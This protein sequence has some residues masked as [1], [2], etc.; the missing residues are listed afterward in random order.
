MNRCLSTDRSIDRLNLA[1]PPPHTPSPHHPF[2]VPA[3]SIPAPAGAAAPSDDDPGAPS[4][5]R[6][7]LSSPV[8]AMVD[9]P[10]PCGCRAVCGSVSGLNRPSRSCE[11]PL[12]PSIPTASLSIDRRTA[13]PPVDSCIAPSSTARR[14]RRPSCGEPWAATPQIKQFKAQ[15]QIGAGA[16]QIIERVCLL[17]FHAHIH[18]KPWPGPIWA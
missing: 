13:R 7:S 12:R 5:T 16:T 17:P 18:P 15:A 14:R 10:W 6:A 4:P 2:H 1:R 8:A 9:R 3:W 11:R